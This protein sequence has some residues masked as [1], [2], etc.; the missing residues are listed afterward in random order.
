MRDDDEGKPSPDTDRAA[1]LAR[2][3]QFIAIALSGLATTTACTSGGDKAQDGKSTQPD[4]TDKGEPI[5]PTTADPQPCLSVAPPTEPEPEPIAPHPC[6][7][8]AAPEPSGE[9]GEALPDEPPP[10]EP[11]PR[12]CLKKMP[13]KPCLKMPAPEDE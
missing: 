2:R 11:K 8:I 1:I 13:P 12:P 9:T 5:Q 7:K 10:P 3:K 4:K 6:L